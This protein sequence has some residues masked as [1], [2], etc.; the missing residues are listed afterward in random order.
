MIQTLI[1]LVLILHGLVHWLYAGH[2]C[3]LFEL[4]TGMTW[5]EDSWLLSSLL[6]T[7]SMRWI[8][9]ISCAFAG[10]LFVAGGVGLLFDASWF[11]NAAITA[12]LFSMVLYT[13]LW[14]GQRAHLDD[15]GLVGMLINVAI[16]LGLLSFS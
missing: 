8:G 1:A 9:A 3:R 7:P 10:L 4:Q 6:S 12:A 16:I 11:R 14:N 2:S 5:P 15:Q 13:I